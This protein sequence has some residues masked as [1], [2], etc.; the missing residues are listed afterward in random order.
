[1]PT[2]EVIR[3]APGRS[4]AEAGN[5]M[6]MAHDPGGED[7]PSKVG[8]GLH[9][10]H[11]VPASYPEPLPPYED[12]LDKVRDELRYSDRSPALADHA[13]GSLLGPPG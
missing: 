6:P 12:E 11:T 8:H 5:L 13:C 1:M 3:V 2:S 10:L 4:L 9:L 7:E